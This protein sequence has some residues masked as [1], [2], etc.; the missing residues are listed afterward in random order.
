ML[1]GKNIYL[2]PSFQA[3]QLC[4]ATKTL[5]PF[6]L[7]LSLSLARIHRFEEQVI[8]V[9]GVDSLCIQYVYMVDH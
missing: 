3:N 5:A 6:S 1:L 8:H 9:L 7:A 2:G 4:S